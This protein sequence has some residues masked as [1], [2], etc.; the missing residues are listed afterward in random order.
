MGMLYVFLGQTIIVYPKFFADCSRGVYCIKYWIFSNKISPDFFYR[1]LLGLFWLLGLLCGFHV[2]SSLGPHSFLL[3]RMAVG[4]CVSI[5]GA[6]TVLIF[7]VVLSAVLIQVSDVLIF[8][9]LFFK[10]FCYSFC[11]FGISY[12]Y[13]DAGW[14][15]R[16]M[17]LFSGS[18]M[19][20]NLLIFWIRNISVSKTAVKKN[21]ILAICIAVA[22]GIIDLILVSPFLTTLFITR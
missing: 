1:L 10:A 21:Y 22:I 17:L 8:P 4:C 2:A 12:A 6:F 15:V 16:C 11:Y 9:F 14:L 3:M 5:V 7:P 19:A 13:D 18:S 20:L